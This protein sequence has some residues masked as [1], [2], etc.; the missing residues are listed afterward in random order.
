MYHSFWNGNDPEFDDP[1]MNEPSAGRGRNRK[2]RRRGASSVLTVLLTLAVAGGVAYVLLQRYDIPFSYFSGMMEG[3]SSTEPD[4]GFGY[5]FDD[6]VEVNDKASEEYS[7]PQYEGDASGLTIDLQAPSGTELTPS[8]LY[9]EELGACVSVTVYAESSAAYGSGMVL[10]PDGFILTCAHVVDDTQSAVITTSDGT[11]YDAELVGSDAQSDLAV[12]KIDAENLPCV[13]FADSDELVIGEEICVIGNPLGPQFAYSLTDGIVSGLNRSVSSD[14]YA[15]SL[16]QVSAAVNSGN[17]GGPLFNSR[18]Q[19][20][21]VVNMKISGNG[22]AVSVDNMGLA[23]PSRTVKTVVESLAATGSVERAVLGISCYAV[24]ETSAKLN[25]MPEGLWVMSMDDASDCAAQ[26]LLLGDMITAVDGKEVSSVTE[27]QAMT[28]DLKVGDS[29][30]LTIWRD[31]GLAEELEAAQ[32]DSSTP[33]EEAIG[34]AAP[35][36]DTSDGEP[37]EE[38]DFAYYGEI[39]V[40]LISSLELKN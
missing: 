24:D 40:R 32:A 17:S 5:D 19:V 20:I 2:H 9:E 7:L 8:Q 18:G 26:G 29:V 1:W 16:I 27:F 34:S 23:V 21:G 22:S 36:G 15:M 33:A 30:M 31:P 35:E 39:T 10:T 12:L 13:T 38:Y 37:T 28:A 6:D 14:G 25:G 4:E 3:D 11:E